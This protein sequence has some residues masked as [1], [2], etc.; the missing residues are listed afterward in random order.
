M[1]EEIRQAASAMG[2]KGGKS[3]SEAKLAAVRENIKKATAS[4]TPEQRLERAKKASR[5]AA[6]SMTPEQKKE[7]ARK[8]VAARWAK[9]KGLDCG[10]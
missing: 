6:A 3:R 8:A 10:K 2:R 7:R 9:K 1:E 5:A 4:L